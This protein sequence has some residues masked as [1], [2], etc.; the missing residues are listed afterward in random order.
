MCGLNLT[1]KFSPDFHK[2]TA[3]DR[4][5]NFF[6][7]FIIAPPNKLRRLQTSLIYKKEKNNIC[8]EWF[9]AGVLQRVSLKFHKIHRYIPLAG[10][11]S[12]TVK[13]FHALRLT[14]LLKRDTRI[15]VSEPAIRRSTI[16]LLSNSVHRKTPLLESF[17][18]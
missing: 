12:N 5:I 14:T 3:L 13:C 15:G 8:E 11:L 17:F 10:S 6:S 1:M 2:Y 16:K 7:Q 9:L 18:K 4:L